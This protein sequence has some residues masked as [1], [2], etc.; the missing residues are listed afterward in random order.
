MWFVRIIPC[1]S[2]AICSIRLCPLCTSSLTSAD[3]DCHVCSSC[4]SSTLD[5]F[6]AHVSIDLC[7]ATHPESESQ[8]SH[9]YWTGVRALIDPLPYLCL[10]GVT[11]SAHLSSRYQPTQEIHR[12]LAHLE[13]SAEAMTRLVRHYKALPETFYCTVNSDPVGPASLLHQLRTPTFRPHMKNRSSN[14]ILQS[15]AGLPTLRIR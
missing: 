1:A 11:P 12:C 4:L 15:K 3:V 13:C 6:T 9:C 5:S 10:S 8:G 2:C 14:R 7:G